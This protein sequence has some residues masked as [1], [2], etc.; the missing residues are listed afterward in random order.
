ML[1]RPKLVKKLKKQMRYG[2]YN[3]SYG[4]RMRI[5]ITFIDIK[6]TP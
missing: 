1:Q 5:N 3:C 2:S 6:E 4:Y